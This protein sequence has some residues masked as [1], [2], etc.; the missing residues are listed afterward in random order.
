MAFAVSHRGSARFDREDA[1]Q[2]IPTVDDVAIVR[3]ARRAAGILAD[4]LQRRRIARD[5]DHEKTVLIMPDG[6]DARDARADLLGSRRIGVWPAVRRLDLNRL[7]AAVVADEIGAAVRRIA[8]ERPDPM[9]DDTRPRG[10]HIRS[11]VAI[12]ARVSWSGEREC[13]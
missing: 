11:V 13:D 3:A 1:R 9:V 12:G 4:G 6:E 8:F 5:R 2:S 10:E 7:I